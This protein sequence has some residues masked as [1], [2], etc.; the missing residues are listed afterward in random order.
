[1]SE[2]LAIIIPLVNANEPGA[3]LAELN[4]KTGQHVM[5]GEK[6]CTLETTKSTLELMAEGEGYVAGLK[7]K[8]GQTIQAS[9]VLQDSVQ[10]L[11]GLVE[12]K[13]M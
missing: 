1:M 2:S 9:G 7:A 8:Q 13:T 11:T 10:L 4:V 6:L 5:A 3:L 12:M